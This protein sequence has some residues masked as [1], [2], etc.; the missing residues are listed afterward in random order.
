MPQQMTHLGAASSETH[1]ATLD[2]WP[3]TMRALALGNATHKT[4]A[5]QFQTS[6]SFWATSYR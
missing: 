2:R 1:D 5:D 3:Q 4:E 6:F